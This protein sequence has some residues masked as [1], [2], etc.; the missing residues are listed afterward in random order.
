LKKAL[1]LAIVMVLGLG[2]VAFAG[3]FSGSWDTT[4]SFGIADPFAF[5]G[6]ASNLSLTYSVCGWDFSSVSAFD[7][8]GFVDQYFTAAG[9]L[10]AFTF[11][12][13]LNFDPSTPAFEMWLSGAKVS[14]AGVDLYGFFDLEDTGC[15]WLFG[16]SGSAGDCTMAAEAYFNLT[17]SLMG[18]GYDFDYVVGNF[19]DFAYAYDAIHGCTSNT[20]TVA[21]NAFSLQTDSC[22]MCWSGIDA[23]VTFP[24]ACVEKVT[25]KASFTCDDGFKYFKAELDDIELGVAWLTIDDF[26][27]TWALTK[28]TVTVDLDITIDSVCLTPYFAI[29]PE[30][31]Y[32]N[33]GFSISS[34]ELYAL[35]LSWDFGQG[36]TVN[37]ITLLDCVNYGLTWGGSP[38]RLDLA[39]LGY[40]CVSP[41]E[42]LF[43]ISYS[44]DA[45]CGGAF[46]LDIKNWFDIACEDEQL[47]DSLLGWGATEV[48]FSVGLGSNFTLSSSY[49]I[50]S[51]NVFFTGVSQYWQVG[52][53][54]TF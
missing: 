22:C 35:G 43:E 34:L 53:G 41:Y 11:G 48:S 47:A 5:V 28:K 42:E 13:Y 23:K 32:G 39:G 46:E 51:T 31:T 44:S 18:Y 2:A 16:A 17:D 15:G 14:I 12:S 30:G 7:V 3:P 29:N 38:V 8:T 49:G 6:F 24:F 40:Y 25:F 9:S 54:V 50:A 20:T 19:A 52:F 33:S 1:V 36:I 37:S 26:D 10:G 21:D 27:I 4:L 45:C